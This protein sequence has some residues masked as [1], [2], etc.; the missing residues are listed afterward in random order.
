M[1]RID[2]NQIY[3]GTNGRV[4]MDG[5]LMSAVKKFEAKMSVDYEDVDIN[6]EMCQQKRMMGYSISGTM[7][8]H[9]VDSYILK[10]Y[11]AAILSGMLP[12]ITMV[13]SE[14]DPQTGATQRIALYGV[15]LDEVALAN[16]ENRSLLEEEVPFTASRVELLDVA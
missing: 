5:D 16:F 10:N 8:L 12:D 6:G 15:K 4:W 9:K 3:N 13:A 2:A 11:L 1:A 7:P 14:N